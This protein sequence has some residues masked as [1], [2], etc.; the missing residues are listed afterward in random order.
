MCVWGPC[1]L[2]VLI[3]PNLTVS[4]AHE[5]T[6]GRAPVWGSEFTTKGAVIDLI[7]VP[8]AMPAAPLVVCRRYLIVV[9]RSLCVAGT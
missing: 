8:R 5:R 4:P 1:L 2:A 9:R 3:V 6:E 7:E